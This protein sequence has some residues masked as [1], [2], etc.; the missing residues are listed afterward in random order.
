MLSV[1]VDVWSFYVVVLYIYI[2][3]YCI[4]IKNTKK[5]PKIAR[6]LVKTKTD[7]FCRCLQHKAKFNSN[8]LQLPQQ[9]WTSTI[10]SPDSKR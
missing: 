8:P 2:Y 5:R 6:L 1:V 10:I 4:V 3:I 9:T 7:V